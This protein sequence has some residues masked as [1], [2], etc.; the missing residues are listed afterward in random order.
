MKCY[1]CEKEA[2]VKVELED[3]SICVYL[4]KTHFL[5]REKEESWEFN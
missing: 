3:D 5:E 2:S 4:C 1:D